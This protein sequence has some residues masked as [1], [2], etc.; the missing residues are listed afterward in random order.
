[1][2]SAGTRSARLPAIVALAA[3]LAALTAPPVAARVNGEAVVTAAVQVTADTNPVRAHATPQIVR[4]PKTGE[5]VVADVDV[6]GAR[7]CQVHVSNDDGRS[8]SLGGRLMIEPY[9]DCS[10]GSEY[11]PHVMPFFDAGGTLYVATTASDPKDLHD[12]QREPTAEFPRNRSFIPRN[13]YLSRSTDGGRTFTTKLVF[14]GP[15]EDPHHGYNYAPVGAVD[16]RHPS[17]VYVG[18]TQ[19]EWQSPKEPSKAM[20]A[21]SSDGGATFANPVD[22]SIKQGSEHPWVAVGEDG[23][24]H[25]TYWD[26]GFGKPL[27]TPPPFVPTARQDPQPI[28]Y[29]RSTDQGRTWERQDLDPGAQS[30]YRP[31]VIATAP[32]SN[33][34]Y[35][36]WYSTAERNNY[37]M[38]RTGKDRTDIYFRASHDGGKTWDDRKI[39]NDDPGKGVNHSLPGMSVAP[40][41]RIDI[42]W[43]DARNSPN[44]SGSP[45]RDQG[46]LDI[47]ASSS[48]DGGRTFAPSRR[49]NDRAI[50]RSLGVWSANV[51]ASVAV[52]VSST[53]DSAY[54]AWQD[55][56]AGNPTTSAEDVYMA[57]LKLN[58]TRDVV[59]RKRAGQEWF[60]AGGGLLLGLG[61]GM[62]AAWAVARR[63]GPGADRRGS[64]ATSA[65]ESPTPSGPAAHAQ[66]RAMTSLR[67]VQLR[68]SMARSRT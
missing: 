55:S 31:P 29:V 43:N 54:F 17:R 68:C 48:T 33:D 63:F 13:V 22:I 2:E 58:G 7:E 45:S 12:E 30:Y 51:N 46:L 44:S 60:E 52:G 42:A 25:A 62:V 32:N 67:Q 9:T 57:A 16:P 65:P 11:G 56:R 34:V 6:R 27:P 59:T 8:W 23:T 24:V 4:S 19:G 50:D 38:A 18:W 64:A 10:V 1:V 20:I 21:A 3:G 47:Y 49:I 53:D 61:I 41:G 5:L 15:E 26:K 28:V 37:D 39:V 40:D 66:R 36:V 35:V 14:R